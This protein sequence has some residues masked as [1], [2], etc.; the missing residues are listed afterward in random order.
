MQNVW[1]DRC[2]GVW[3]VRLTMTLTGIVRL[4][5]TLHNPAGLADKT[6]ATILAPDYRRP[7]E[8]PHPTPVND[9]LLAYEWL[10]QARA[11]DPPSPSPSPRHSP[12]II[13]HSLH[14]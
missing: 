7:P 3:H 9:G 6:K 13:N 2:V 8:H 10:L 11:A 1:P 12:K 5:M 4:T 14:I